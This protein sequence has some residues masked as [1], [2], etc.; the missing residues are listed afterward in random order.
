MIHFKYEY[1]G[2]TFLRGH[3]CKDLEDITGTRRVNLTR[4]GKTGRDEQLDKTLDL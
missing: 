4:L 2:D 1:K 3:S